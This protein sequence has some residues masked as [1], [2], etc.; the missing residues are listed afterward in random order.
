[1]LKI[2]FSSIL[3]WMIIIYCTTS[4]FKNAIVKNGWVDPN[5]KSAENG[6]KCLFILSAIPIIRFLIFVLIIMMSAYTKK[7]FEEWSEKVKNKDE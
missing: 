7:Q 5:K 6:W 4:I 3:I 2:Y 1:M